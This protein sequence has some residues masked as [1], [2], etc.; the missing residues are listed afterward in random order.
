MYEKLP[1]HSTLTYK[2]SDHVLL[3]F[4]QLLSQLFQLLQVTEYDIQYKNQWI[5]EYLQWMLIY[6]FFAQV[7][8]LVLCSSHFE[9]SEDQSIP[10]FMITKS[11]FGLSWFYYHQC[12]YKM[13]SFQS[14]G[15]S[16]N[17]IDIIEGHIFLGC[18][19]KDNSYMTRRQPVSLVGLWSDTNWIQPGRAANSITWYTCIRWHICNVD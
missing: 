11:W 13:I 19:W 7:H 2:Q 14:S 6:I 12:I 5:L 15:C 8:G 1:N 17:I 16:Y 3:I 10:I 18:K 9:N 4:H